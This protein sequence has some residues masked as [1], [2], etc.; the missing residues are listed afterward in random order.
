MNRKKIKFILLLKLITIILIPSTFGM[1][2]EILLKE[3]FEKRREYFNDEACHLPHPLQLLLLSRH[4]YS[5]YTREFNELAEKAQVAY[6]DDFFKKWNGEIEL[7]L[8]NNA[9]LEFINE[10]GGK[11]NEQQK[12]FVAVKTYYLCINKNIPLYKLTS[13]FSKLYECYLNKIP[14]T[15]KILMIN[16][17]QKIIQPHLPIGSGSFNN[18]IYYYLVFLAK[19]DP[20]PENKKLYSSYEKLDKINSQIGL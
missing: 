18:D 15:L 1:D 14:E 13:V 17:C 8:E 9:F 7:P 10:W 12:L 5:K 11:F 20:S 3:Y 19:I 2:V 16:H 4:P 6:V